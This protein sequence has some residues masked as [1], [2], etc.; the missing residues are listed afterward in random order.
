MKLPL[1]TTSYVACRAGPS[2]AF[3]AA[4]RPS[5]RALCTSIDRPL[6]SPAAKMCS[7]L[8]AQVLVDGDRAGLG[9]DAGRAEV[10]R[11]EVGGPADREEDGVADLRPGPAGPR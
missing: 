8:V 3:V 6:T 9:P 1:G 10:Q 2:T 5:I 11:A 4:T 7:T